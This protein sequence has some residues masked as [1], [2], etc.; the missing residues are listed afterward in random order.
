MTRAILQAPGFIYLTELGDST[1]ASPAGKTTLTPHEIASLLSY[2]ATAGP[3]DRALLDNVDAL[4]TADGREQQLRRL[5]PTLEARTRLVRVVR[6]WLGID[7]VAELDKDSNVYPS[8]AAHHN[9]MAAESVS[10]IDEVLSNGAGTLQELL[11][12]EWTIID[13]PTAPPTRRSAP[14]T[15]ATTVSA[16]AGRRRR[17]T[18]SAAPRAAP[19]WGS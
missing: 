1:A 11:G 6:E 10:F 3:P 19:A 9:A 17:R 18:C 4:V 13:A 16:R 15:P 7:G 12:A 5:L 14:T 2:L 8:F